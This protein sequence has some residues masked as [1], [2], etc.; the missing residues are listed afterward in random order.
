MEVGESNG[1]KVR[2]GGSAP[3]PTKSPGRGNANSHAKAGK[4]TI[5]HSTGSSTNPYVEITISDNA[6]KAHARHHDGR[7][8]IPAP[9][10]RLRGHRGA[11][12]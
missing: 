9:R 11:G 6:L 7:D 2:R 3:A 12:R 10:R 5:C 8:I 4:T 1:R